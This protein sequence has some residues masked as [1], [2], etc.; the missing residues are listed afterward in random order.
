M[1]P[2]YNMS[3]NKRVGTAS[4]ELVSVGVR[5]PVQTKMKAIM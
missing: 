5:L 4:Y 3:L 1:T 2:A